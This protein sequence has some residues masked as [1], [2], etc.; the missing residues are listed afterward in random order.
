MIRLTRRVLANR[1]REC[2]RGEPLGSNASSQL[3]SLDELFELLL[4]EL[5]EKSELFE[6]FEF[7]LEFDEF[8]FELLLLYTIPG[9]SRPLILV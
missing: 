4:L 5:R 3:L 9:P 8:E 1:M 6:L 2:G 7:E